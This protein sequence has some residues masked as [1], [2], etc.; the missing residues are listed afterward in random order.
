MG[1]RKGLAGLFAAIASALCLVLVAVVVGVGVSGSQGLGAPAISER[2]E[3]SDASAP[4]SEDDKDASAPSEEPDEEDVVIE[5]D[6]PEYVGSDEDAGSWDASQCRSGEVLV[7]VAE[8]VTV[9]EL[10]EQLADLDFVSTSQ[11]ASDDVAL[12]WVKLE[13]SGNE[14]LDEQISALKSTGA[15][16]DA[17]PNFVYHLLEDAGQGAAPSGL[18]AG[19][20]DVL[21]QGAINDKVALISEN[22]WWLRAVNAFE[23][24]K[25][26]KV[27]GSVTVAIIDT[28]CDATHEDLSASISTSNCYNAL[29]GGVGKAAVSDSDGHG[30]HVAGIISAVPNNKIGV[31][32]VSYGARLMP[33]KVI[34]RKTTDT[35]YLLRAYEFAMARRAAGENVRVINMSLG[36]SGGFDPALMRAIDRA[37]Y[38]YGILAVFAGGNDGSAVPYDCF[39]CDYAEVGLGVVAVGKD[40]AYGLRGYQASSSNYNKGSQKTKAL[41]APG[42]VIASTYPSSLAGT[43]GLGKG[44]CMLSGTSMAAPVVSGIAALVAARNPS[45]SA[46]ELKSVLCSTTADIV[47]P[48]GYG[49]G[50]DQ[51]T[52]YGLVRADK[53]V[54][55]AFSSYIAGP[56]AVAVGG[57]IK[58]AVPQS[59][60]WRWS[61]S[62]KAVATVSSSG[63]VSGKAPG[64]V[65]ISA[66]NSATGAR[67]SRTIVVYEAKI[68]GAKTV[69]AGKAKALSAKT[70]PLAMCNWTSSKPKVATV[71]PLTGVVTGVKTGT[72][73]ITATL[74]AAP[75]VKVKKK[76]KVVKGPNPM[77]VVGCDQVV[78]QDLVKAKA[79]NVSGAFQFTTRAKGRVTYTKVSKGSSKYLSINKK[80]G[81]IKVKK[82]TP[83]GVYKIKVKVRA[84]GNSSY[85]AKTTKVTVRIT[86]A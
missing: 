2:P 82:G 34:E 9:D 69:K 37:Y 21:T 6:E 62:S 64:E 48:G 16:S 40:T 65:C 73:T 5:D 36:G 74:T 86:V 25:K 14:S 63:K 72:T 66:V 18:T 53:A 38:D 78:Q 41:A 50:F 1:R 42:M 47:Q 23:A 55:G 60:S 76:V 35:S 70:N 49:V 4:A 46:G 57:S 20:S 83:P 84:A 13:V 39:P 7:Q 58:L 19:G 29:T 67:L 22:D 59:G 45:L 30:T 52:G 43:G 68:S 15:V 51:F 80:N 75:N 28:G 31:A 85:K 26:C 81:K 33:I 54:A 24:W 61:S 17:Q 79:R 10:N 12:G 8:G 77:R 27:S 3:A 11:V 56:D 44:Y 71:D 32:G